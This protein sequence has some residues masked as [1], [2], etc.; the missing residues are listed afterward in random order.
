MTTDPFIQILRTF[1]P[2]LNVINLSENTLITYE[3]MKIL[4]LETKLKESENLI[5]NQIENNKKI[6]ELNNSLLLKNISL[7]IKS[8]IDLSETFIEFI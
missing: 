3:N 1:N 6:N 2:T 8:I 7:N 5:E 4:K